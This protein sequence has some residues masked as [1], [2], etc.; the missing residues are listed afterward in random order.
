LAAQESAA[1]TESIPSLYTKVFTPVDPGAHGAR[2]A[3]VP[4]IFKEIRIEALSLGKF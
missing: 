2:T 1:L 4:V 3:G